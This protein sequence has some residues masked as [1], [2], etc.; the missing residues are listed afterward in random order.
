MEGTNLFDQSSIFVDVTKISGRRTNYT[1]DDGRLYEN[2]EGESFNIEFFVI[3]DLKPCFFYME[4]E[5]RE[6]LIGYWIQREREKEK[7]KREAIK[8]SASDPGGFRFYI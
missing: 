3:S 8:L 6:S 1:F 4:R 5:K 7:R 2:G